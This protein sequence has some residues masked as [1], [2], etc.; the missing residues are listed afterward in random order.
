[1]TIWPT[2]FFL[3][4]NVWIA[5]KISLKFVP[6]VRIDYISALAQMIGWHRPGGRATTGTIGGQ[7]TD[8]NIRHYASMS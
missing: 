1:M 6:E 3:D 7:F 5:F 2:T 4:E 8:A